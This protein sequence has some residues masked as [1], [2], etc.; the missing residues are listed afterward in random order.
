VRIPLAWPPP[1]PAFDVVG[2][3]LNSLDLLVLVAE[4]PPRNSKQ[5]MLRL[6]RHPGG[7]AAT[8]MVTCARLGFRTR[9]IGRFGDD[10]YGREGRASLEHEGV[11]VA[12]A[13]LLPGVTNQFAV[14]LVDAASGERTI[15]WHRH[16]GLRM[17]AADIREAA[18][19]AGRV[20]LVDC[21]DTE[22]AT[23][24]ARYARRA[25]IVTVV[26]VE[27]VRPG[28]GE[29]LGEIDV[30]I[31]SQQFP[32]ALTGHS[33]PGRALAALAREYSAK[34]VCTTLG[35]EGSL[36]L[37]SGQEIRTPGFTQIRCV[38]S[39]GAGDVF[40]GGFI[41]GFLAGGPEVDLED[42][43]RYANAVAAL[44]CRCLGARDGIP[45]GADVQALLGR[46]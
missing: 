22:A 8:A 29:L 11:D 16:P 39:T 44:K 46:A 32:P 21:H 20:L 9:Y 37:A 24:A 28:I 35:A 42:V 2:V 38:D 30:I 13:P 45:R 17:S 5:P 1:G 40:R 6:G 25:G 12:E 41:A 31:A 26:D 15:M 43:L 14:I 34:I 4:H 18:V 23:R 10:E 27:Q 7:Q 33:E 19:T 36:A 3:G